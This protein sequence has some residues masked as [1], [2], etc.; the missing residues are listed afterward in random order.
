M[1]RH[2]I[3]SGISRKNARK[4]MKFFRWLFGPEEKGKKEKYEKISDK[5]PDFRKVFLSLPDIVKATILPP[6]DPKEANA[7]SSQERDAARLSAENEAKAATS[8]EKVDIVHAR[9]LTAIGKD[10]EIVWLLQTDKEIQHKSLDDLLKSYRNMKNSDSYRG[11]SVNY[12]FDGKLHQ[13][14]PLTEQD[15]EGLARK[16][17]MGKRRVKSPQQKEK[18]DNHG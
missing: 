12:D 13:I 1:T 10:K 2:S 7:P 6:D 4:V 14:S 17:E 16:L 5:M 3:T 11:M 15:L 9:I 8:K 18:G